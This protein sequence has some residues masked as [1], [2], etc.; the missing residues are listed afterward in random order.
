MS[1]QSLRVIARVVANDHSIEPLKAILISLVAPTREEAGCLQYNLYQNQNDP[2][3]FT[4]IEE[5]A[6]A[7]ALEA[8]L[9]GDLIQQAMIDVMDFVTAPPD[10]QRFDRV[11]Y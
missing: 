10:I 1:N 6:S 5:W 8:H 4:F 9:S 7:A 2:R 11:C 3:E